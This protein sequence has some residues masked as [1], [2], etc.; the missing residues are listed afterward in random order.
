MNERDNVIVRI[1]QDVVRYDIK[2][3]EI[4]AAITADMFKQEKKKD[5]QDI[6]NKSK[7][8]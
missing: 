6:E 8:K 5:V 1:A 2:G 7:A 3:K 4:A